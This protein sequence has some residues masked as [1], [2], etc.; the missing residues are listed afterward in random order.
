M[1]FSF[2]CARKLNETAASRFPCHG[3]VGETPKKQLPRPPG[4]SWLKRRRLLRRDE[5]RVSSLCS[6]GDSRSVS[7]NF[8]CLQQSPTRIA[9]CMTP[10]LD[11]VA[12]AIRIDDLPCVCWVPGA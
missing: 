10:P 2:A 5:A 6:S 1:A 12:D 7:S 4:R 11:L 9:D 8:E 3:F